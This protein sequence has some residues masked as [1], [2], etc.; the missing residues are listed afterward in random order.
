[1][2]SVAAFDQ[3][4]HLAWGDVA[5][6]EINPP[7]AVRVH[8]K[9][10]KCDQLGKGVD[11]FVGKTGG[12]LCPVAAIVRYVSIRGPAA[13]PFFIRDDGTPLTK[14]AFVKKVREALAS[15]GLAPKDYAGH[16]F[17][18]GAATAASQ[19]GLEDSVIQSLGRW[20]SAAF[21]RY[22]RTPREQLASYS[23]ALTLMR[24]RHN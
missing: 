17:R 19:A 23:K 6:S 11:V 16:S 21:L 2:P 8:L 1:M 13:G 7:S 4:V 5:V 9:R 22:I 15:L 24:R 12:A 20:S 10:S 14:A 18:I 3:K